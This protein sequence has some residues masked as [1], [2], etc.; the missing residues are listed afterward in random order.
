MSVCEHVSGTSHPVFTSSFVHVA[1]AVARFSSSSI[2]LAF[3]LSFFMDDVMFAHSGP[4]GDAD[5]IAASGII[6]S[7]CT[8]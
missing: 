3:V 2:A 1:Y 4:Y 6:V 5:T 8:G 7:S